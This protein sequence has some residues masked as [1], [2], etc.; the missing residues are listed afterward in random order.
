MTAPP[1][2]WRRLPAGVWALGAVSLFM[3][4]SSE[5]I[6]GLL[7]V[8][9]VGVLGASL[10]SVGAIEGI[11]EATASLTR[12]FSGALSDA[13]RRRKLPTLAG[14]ALA[15][16]SKPLFALAPSLAWV[17]VA[18]VVDRLGKGIR[19]APRDAL[20]A[21][22]T[23]AALRGAA[24]GLRQSLDTVGAIAGPLA[25]IA[26]MAAFAGDIR[27]VLWV[28][29]GPAMLAVVVL[30]VGV[31]EPARKAGV[32]ET[33][34]PR[35]A[36]A[37]ALGAAFWALTGLAVLLG[38]AR[39]SEAFLVLRAS[40]LGLS[41]EWVPMVLVV[42]NVVYAAAA[43]PAGVLSDRRGRRAPLVA[44]LGLLVAADL[45]L[46]AAPGLAAAMVGVALWGLHL[47]LTQGLLSALV[48]DAV[49]ARLRG[50]AFGVFHTAA[51]LAALAASLLAGALWDSFG[52]AAPFLAGA[53]FALAAGALAFRLR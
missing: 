53:L 2:V 27:A 39:F 50:T 4:T 13:L 52:A 34:P 15:A 6:H 24:Y 33:R 30:A 45:V 11:A 8:F 36:D 25:A 40:A 26:L 49:P 20:V 12:V 7:P 46:A 38:L 14:Y 9:M 3:D 41:A 37:R 43:Y 31:R 48:A 19:G 35:L 47:G 18:R 44:G 51:G 22:I 29:L 21:D 23:P 16:A 10:T 5:L 1:P 17:L 42:M 28:A 32:I